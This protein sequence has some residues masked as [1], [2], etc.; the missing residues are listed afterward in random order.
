MIARESRYAATSTSVHE[1]PDGTQVLYLQRRFLPQPD[2]VPTA[3]IYSAKNR[4]ARLDT[5]AA[6][7]IGE[8]QAYWR[9]CDVNG[10]LNP[11]DLLAECGYHVRVPSGYTVR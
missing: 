8:P 2:D 11:F 1:A 9:V 10:A 3:R 7:V 6:A 5:I 4:E